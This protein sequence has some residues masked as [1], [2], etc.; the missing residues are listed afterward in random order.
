M[1]HKV[2]YILCT[3]AETM[4]QLVNNDAG[5]KIAITVRVRGVP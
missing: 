1:L 4:G 5:L 3:D 2:S